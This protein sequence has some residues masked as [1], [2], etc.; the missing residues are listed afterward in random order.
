MNDDWIIDAPANANDST[1]VLILAHGAGAPAFAPFMQRMAELISARG[2]LVARFNF[3]YMARAL[4]QQ[5]KLPPPRAERLMDEYRA[6]VAH[7]RAQG[8]VPFIGG[9]S[10]G[11][12]VASMLAD[13]LFGNGDIAGLI[14]LGYPFHAPGRPQNPRIDH[15][16]SLRCPALICQG[17]RDPFG[18]RA[19]VAQYP[20]SE[21]VD[22]CWLPDGDHDFKPRVKSGETWTGN[23]EQ[24]AECCAQFITGR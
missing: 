20:L 3:A 19:Q 12:R 23:M 4:A 15:L 17:E 8:R 14:C 24:A 7:W 22:F 6:R 16:R 10:L 11:G 18:T 5:R 13:E 1:P 21:T 9:K 2:V